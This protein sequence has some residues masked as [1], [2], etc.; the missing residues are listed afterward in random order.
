[1]PIWDWNILVGYYSIIHLYIFNTIFHILY[2]FPRSFISQMKPIIW[3]K[4]DQDTNL[5]SGTK[6]GVRS[7]IKL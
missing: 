7:I 3:L 5:K 2:D 6:N 1:M 4:Y